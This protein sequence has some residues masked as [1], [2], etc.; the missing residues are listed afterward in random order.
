MYILEYNYNK[1]DNFNQYQI[2]MALAFRKLDKNRSDFKGIGIAVIIQDYEGN[3]EIIT[4]D[5]RNCYGSSDETTKNAEYIYRT[6]PQY[7]ENIALT[8]NFTKYRIID[9]DENIQILV[10]AYN[11]NQE[12]RQTENTNFKVWDSMNKTEYKSNKN[13]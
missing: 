2:L 3:Y 12:L 11:L 6:L 7:P 9:M 4:I 13:N 5:D 1:E 8:M 10:N